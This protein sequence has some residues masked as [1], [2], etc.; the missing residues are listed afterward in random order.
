MV[1]GTKEPTASRPAYVECTPTGALFFYHNSYVMHSNKNLTQKLVSYS[2]HNNPISFSVNGK[3]MVN[4]TNMAK[5]FGKRPVAWLRFN[6]SKE[7]IETLSKVRNHTLTDLV[8]VIH[9]GKMPVTWM[10][11]DVALEFARWLS[12]EFAIW[13][14]DRI[15]EILLGKA[16]N[17]LPS[18]SRK[19]NR[20]KIDTYVSVEENEQL[21]NLCRAYGFS[22]S[23]QLLQSLVRCFLSV[24]NPAEQIIQMQKEID[25][26]KCR[27]QDR[28][29]FLEEILPMIQE[30][31]RTIIKLQ[32]VSDEEKRLMRKAKAAMLV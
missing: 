5:P 24:A 10:H 4:A 28:C 13:C 23:Y 3:V 25:Y 22:S 19:Y 29:N 21:K 20:Q 31:N 12:P 11:E 6:Q 27:Y 17:Q 8:Q 18:P 7:Y 26:W 1:V 9:G 16:N 32:K 30:M 14:N 2:Y 15:K